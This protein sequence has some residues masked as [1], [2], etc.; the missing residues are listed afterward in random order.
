M[1]YLLAHP[2]EDD[3][4]FD[5][6]IAGRRSSLATEDSPTDDVASCDL[7]I[8]TELF[9]L[10]PESPSECRLEDVW[11]LEVLTA[12]FMP[13]SQDAS[14]LSASN[15]AKSHQRGIAD[16]DRPIQEP[17]SVEL[18]QDGAR[19]DCLESAESVKESSPYSGLAGV[20]HG[21]SAPLHSPTTP[22]P[23]NSVSL[24]SE[25][26][27][28]IRR[29]ADGSPEGLTDEVI[30][31][32]VKHTAPGPR[33][34]GHAEAI[35]IV[36]T[37]SSLDVEGAGV[38]IAELWDPETR[39]QRPNSDGQ[40]VP[41]LRDDQ[42]HSN[43]PDG[44]R[45]IENMSRLRERP[46][47]GDNCVTGAILPREQVVQ[48]VRHTCRKYAIQ[49]SEMDPS[50]V[51]GQDAS[52]VARACTSCAPAELAKAN[53]EVPVHVD[54]AD[55]VAAPEQAEPVAQV[56][57]TDVTHTGDGR[58]NKKSL[59]SEEAVN[60][61]EINTQ[62]LL[63]ERPSAGCCIMT[64]V[65]IPEDS[66]SDDPNLSAGGD[67]AVPSYQTVTKTAKKRKCYGGPETNQSE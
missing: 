18:K 3:C 12:P 60:V 19:A 44:Q 45:G 32:D 27:S 61:T 4:F 2:E 13:Q 59:P 20:S 66:N 51:N 37:M 62:R 47:I 25:V 29:P 9:P 55:K 50:G 8:A 58:N 48:S 22:S 34:G 7:G 26:V 10:F 17:A 42:A 65:E 40:D 57:S 23:G 33:D 49:D 16:Q 31:D 56:A 11:T 64:A 54:N 46:Q 1:D 6:A 39:F 35:L 41:T 28:S 52:V 53:D 14:I 21:N 36:S 30:S 63:S 15:I 5:A 38:G 24:H 67:D 43:V